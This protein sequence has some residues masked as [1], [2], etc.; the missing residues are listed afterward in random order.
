MS[1]L[2][3]IA[4]PYAK[5]AFDFAIE[6]SAVEKWTEMLGFAAAVAEDEAVKAYLSSSLSAQK[7]A[8]TVISICGEQLDQYGQNLIR[9]MAENKRLSA[10]PTVF[11][12]F[13]HYVEEHQAIAEVEVTSAQ[14][15]NATQIEKN[16]SCNG[17][18]ISS[19]S[20]IKLQRR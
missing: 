15:L 16:C 13:K 2:T 5:A 4:R 11:E 14:P 20:E 17:K 19:Q 1:E 10:I 7:L 6:Q 12:E 3:T 9:L 8:N 18:E